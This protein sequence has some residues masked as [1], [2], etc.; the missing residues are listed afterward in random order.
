[1]TMNKLN[2]VALSASLAVAFAA[3]GGGEK[4]ESETAASE[5]KQEGTRHNGGYVAK[6][7]ETAP[8]PPSDEEMKAKQAAADEKAKKASAN[9]RADFQKLVD[10]YEDAKKK[11]PGIPADD[12][13]WARKFTTSFGGGSF[14]AQ[15]HFNA[16]TI[17]EGCGKAK[18][19]EGEY[20]EALKANP[21]YG[22]A[23]TNLGSLYLRQ[24]NVQTAK[25]WFEKVINSK[26]AEQTAAAYNNLALILYN[27]ARDSGDTSLYKEAVSKLRR[28]LAIDSSS[29]AAYGLLAQIYY[30]TAES[31]RSKLDLAAL[32]CKQAK[33][34]DD[35][36]APIYNTLGLINLKKKNVTGALKEFERAVELDPKFVEAHLNIG[37]I[38]ISSRQYD[39]AAKSFNAVLALQPGNF[40]ATVGMGVA[41]RGLK[42]FDE[43]EKWYRKAS[44]LNPK[45]CTISYNLGLLYQDYKL[46]E[47]NSNLKKAQEYFRTFSGCG[48]ADKKKVDD[49]QRRIKDIDDTFAAI[50]EQKKM[51]AESKKMQE[52]ADRMQ[53]EMEKQQQQQQQQQQAAPD[54]A[55]K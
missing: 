30:Q 4:K 41:S 34:T 55:K 48:S 40:D 45:N 25:Q 2:R 37:A 27:Q 42:Q 43:A 50:E 35:K 20:N 47:D 8:K 33:E 17:L 44:E 1:M 49:A 39:K 26:A 29:V 23:L 3:C 38:A 12:C 19:A 7:N 15:A 28:A 16:G 54:A 46:T 10:A 18:D 14:A 11:P 9:E 13:S 5:K 53:K 31:D 6:E 21:G 36:Y 24:G 32:V 52:E 51:E 22:P